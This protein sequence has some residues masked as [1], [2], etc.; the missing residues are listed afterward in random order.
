MSMFI[1]DSVSLLRWSCS[2]FVEEIWNSEWL[3]VLDFIIRN[4]LD[5]PN[6]NKYFTH[7]IF[8]AEFVLYVFF[9]MFDNLFQQLKH[10]IGMTMFNEKEEVIAPSQINCLKGM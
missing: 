9:D 8:S 6:E 5:N 10:A 7:L 1:Y 2:A 3:C 4:I